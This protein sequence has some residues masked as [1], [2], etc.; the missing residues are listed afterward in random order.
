M[1]LQS[2]EGSGTR[3]SRRNRQEEEIIPLLRP[4]SPISP[5]VRPKI[6]VLPFYSPFSFPQV[7]IEPGKS[8]WA[9]TC[10]QSANFPFCDGSH[11][12]FNAA[13]G[14]NFVPQQVENKG[15]ENMDA[16]MCQCGHSKNRPFCDGSHKNV[17]AV[18]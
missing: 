13:N 1:G 12:A 11:K 2:N 15:T 17:K 4:V 10:G 7:T 8:V 14:T 3:A 9:C 5:Q 6:P 16:W 18:A